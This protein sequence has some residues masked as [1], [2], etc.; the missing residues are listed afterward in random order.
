MAI[1]SIV[2]IILFL[3]LLGVL[4]V[5]THSRQWGYAPTQVVGIVL[6]VLL[7]LAVVGII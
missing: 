6:L 3:M 4:P 1:S 5:W 7:V 2:F